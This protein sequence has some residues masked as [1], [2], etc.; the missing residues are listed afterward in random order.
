[1]EILRVVSGNVDLD[2]QALVGEARRLEFL[3]LGDAHALIA[4]QSFAEKDSDHASADERSVAREALLALEHAVATLQRD[5]ARGVTS[6]DMASSTFSSTSSSEGFSAKGG[7]SAYVVATEPRPFYQSAGFLIGIAALVVLAAAGGWYMF[8][9]SDGTSFEDA[10]SAYVR[11]SRETARIAF[12]RLAQDNPEDARPFIYLG[13]IAREGGDLAEARRFLDRAVRLAPASALAQREMG[14]VMLAEGNTELA[15]RF[16]VRSLEID[17]TDRLAQGLLA[18][19]LHRLG[20]VD[21]ASRWLQ[22]AGPG[23]W[24]PC[25]SMPPGTSAG[26]PAPPAP[27]PR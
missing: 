10:S 22:R 4:L 25:L 3:T 1:M 26:P 11:G 23:E 9:R 6:P 2:G 7:A 20:R 19:S 5:A 16:Y 13:R 14:S 27:G 17:G 21:E 18:C 8:A 24:S 12:A 15:R